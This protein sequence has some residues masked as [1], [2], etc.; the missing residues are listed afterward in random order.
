MPTSKKRAV[1]SRSYCIVGISYAPTEI[2][3]RAIEFNSQYV[4][5]YAYILHDKFSEAELNDNPDKKPHTHIL[6]RLYGK[7]SIK[8]VARWFWYIN[9]EGEIEHTH[10]QSASDLNAYYHYCLHVDYPEKYQYTDDDFECSL[11]CDFDKF[12]ASIVDPLK[13]ALMDI[14]NGTPTRVIMQRYGR[15][16][17]IHSS[18][19]FDVANRIRAEEASRS[20][21]DYERKK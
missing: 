5:D 16:A 9:P 20:I 15:D 8:A 14:L 7:H 12:E 6:L 2:I 10:L 13:D 11:M 19:L 1:S 3:Q 18:Q 4:R 17:I 21:Y